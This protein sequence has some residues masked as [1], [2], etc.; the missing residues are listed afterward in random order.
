[1][2]GHGNRP[3]TRRSGVHGPCTRGAHYMHPVTHCVN[4]I[5]YTRV[6]RV[7][8]S[9]NIPLKPVLYDKRQTVSERDLV[10]ADKCTICFSAGYR[11]PALTVRPWRVRAV[12][13]SGGRSSGRSAR[14]RVRPLAVRRGSGSKGVWGVQSQNEANPRTV[15]GLSYAKRVNLRPNRYF[16][17]CQNVCSY[18]KPKQSKGFMP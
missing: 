18:A 2:P 17:G 1:M 8:L 14:R 10:F 3:L 6:H 7:H 11:T 13:G 15:M 4:A 9:A 16:Y 5:K 12:R